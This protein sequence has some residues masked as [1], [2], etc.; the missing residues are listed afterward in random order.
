MNKL[1]IK[2][3]FEREDLLCEI[4]K[5]S[6]FIPVEHKVFNGKI[7]CKDCIKMDSDKE[8]NIPIKDLQYYMSQN[9]HSKIS[10][11]DI[12]IDI[13]KDN[14]K[15]QMNIEMKEQIDNLKKQMNIEMQ[16]QID[17]LKK[18]MNIEIKEQ[19]DDLKKLLTKSI[20]PNPIGLSDIMKNQS[21]NSEMKPHSDSIGLPAIKPSQLNF[22]KQ[23]KSSNKNINEEFSTAEDDHNYDSDDINNYKSIQIWTYVRIYYKEKREY[24]INIEFVDASTIKIN[25]PQSR[26]PKKWWY[27]YHEK[28][29]LNNKIYVEQSGRKLDLM[30]GMWYDENG[31]SD[32][33]TR[34][35]E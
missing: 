3:D 22:K 15:K 7:L 29:K 4:C 34:I 20:N 30:N 5:D 25:L 2:K 16:G 18:Q 12:N 32:K 9:Y 35:K 24:K 13:E 23:I 10:D 11:R 17:N 6:I 14:L 33:I 21:I 28:N 1:Q 27:Y 26:Y 31:K 19:I 8:D